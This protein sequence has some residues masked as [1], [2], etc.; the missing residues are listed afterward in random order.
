MRTPG[1]ETFVI[2]EI[3]GTAYGVH[4]HSVQQLEMVESI[5]LV[6]N[7]APSV[8]GVVFSRG[9]VVPA[10]SLRA[11]F[12]FEKIPYDLR[13]RL[14]VISSGTRLVGLIADSA[15]EY[16]SIPAEAIQ[17]PPEAITGA[18][19]NYVQGVATVGGRVVI[20]LNVDEVIHG[21]AEPPP[22]GSPDSV[23]DVQASM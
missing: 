5:T 19:V 10:I 20:I 8:E 12:G 22:D 21:I 3:A 4:S 7:A 11:R 17:P 2:M 9:N 15:R 6:P 1:S 16:I 18:S 14:V 23:S 13:T